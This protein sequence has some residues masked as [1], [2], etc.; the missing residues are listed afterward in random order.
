MSIWNNKIFRAPLA[1]TIHDPFI[2]VKRQV[3]SIPAYNHDKKIESLKEK[4]SQTCSSSKVM[5]DF[6]LTSSASPPT[7]SYSILDNMYNDW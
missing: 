6:Y 4:W 1:L 7:P 3:G 2:V 5:T